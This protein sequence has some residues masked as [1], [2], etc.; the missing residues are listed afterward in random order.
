MYLEAGVVEGSKKLKFLCKCLK[1][2]CISGRQGKV[3]GVDMQS[4]RDW[5]METFEEVRTLKLADNCSRHL[6]FDSLL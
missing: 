5:E 3:I 6:Y 4:R 2:Q 1:L